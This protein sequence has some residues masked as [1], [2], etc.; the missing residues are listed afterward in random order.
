MSYLD[1]NAAGE[2]WFVYQ[3]NPGKP[4]SKVVMN[5]Q[6]LACSFDQYTAKCLDIPGNPGD[7][8]VFKVG[9]TDGT[10]DIRDF[11]IPTCQAVESKN[12]CKLYTAEC[13]GTQSISF[14]VD[15]LNKDTLQ[16]VPLMA[17]SVSAISGP[18]TYS[19]Q[20][21]PSVAG[22]IYCV[23]PKQGNGIWSL[24]VYYAT[25]EQPDANAY[26]VFYDDMWNAAKAIGCE[27][28]KPPDE[29]KPVCSA[30]KD[31]PTC[32]TTAGCEW[33][34]VASGGYGTYTCQNQ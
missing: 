26:C 15:V 7:P 1:C 4:Y 31:G 3:R 21:H 25:V 8:A 9:F 10:S 17:G 14:L 29:N 22:R 30:I 18:D 13:V 23:G 12:Q 6:E 19:C 27:E 28:P 11:Q 34:W 32:Q 5:G 2:P 33:V 24:S 16:G 20:L